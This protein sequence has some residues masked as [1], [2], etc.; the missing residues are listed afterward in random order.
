MKTI[1]FVKQQTSL[2]KPNLHSRTRHQLQ[3]YLTKTAPRGYPLPEEEKRVAHE[4]FLKAYL[5]SKPQN[6]QIPGLQEFAASIWDRR[7]H[8]PSQTFH[9]PLQRMFDEFDEDMDGHL[10]AKELAHALQSRNVD[11]S[12]EQ[13]Q[14]FIDAADKSGNHLIE[15]E[16]FA[17]LI[18]YMAT[19]HFDPSKRKKRVAHVEHDKH[20]THENDQQKLQ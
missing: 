13:A 8:I 20:V 11:I 15:K 9:D 16:E 14:K 4:A 17:E 19:R 1:N 7:H 6:Q 18:H 12:E 5:G 3:S 2:K 10:N